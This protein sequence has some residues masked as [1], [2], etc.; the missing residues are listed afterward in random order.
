M[1]AKR[2]KA[3][4]KHEEARDLKQMRDRGG[5]AVCASLQRHLSEE[6]FQVSHVTF[7]DVIISKK[8][9]F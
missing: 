3:L 6:E 2:D 8:S 9:S 7:Y 4:E 5:D 1:I